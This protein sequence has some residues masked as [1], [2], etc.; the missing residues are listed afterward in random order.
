[1][2]NDDPENIEPV[3]PIETPAG[4]Q[5]APVKATPEPAA[6]QVTLAGLVQSHETTHPGFDPAIHA[7]NEDGTPK[8]RADGSYALK[9]GRKAGQTSNLPPK[10]NAPAASVSA[11]T[12][13]EGIT[14]PARISPDEAARQSANLVI[15]C[16]VWICGDKIGIPQD[17]AEADGLLFSFKNYYESRGVPNIPPEIG[18]FAALGSYLVP[19]FRA[20]EKARS[21]FERAGL[22]IK[23]K[24]GK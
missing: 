11:P 5:T 17:K 23:S 16:A 12:Q 9:R 10:G 18:L 2:K 6:D 14:A 1:M 21:L 13:E 19:R 22:W 3:D 20:S 15:N 7:A 8:R 24:V 4:D